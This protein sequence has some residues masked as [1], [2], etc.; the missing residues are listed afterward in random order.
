MAETPTKI[1]VDLVVPIYTR[2]NGKE[3]EL[4]SYPVSVPI[5]VEIGVGGRE[6]PAVE[7][8]PIGFYRT[9]EPRFATEHFGFPLYG[10]EIHEAVDGGKWAW[11]RQ[12][13]V[14]ELR[15]YP[16]GGPN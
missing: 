5:K 11:D 16:P 2:L 14:W 6:K 10:D 15:E 9:L 1:T 3:I 13:R 7:V 8:K 4:G 12:M